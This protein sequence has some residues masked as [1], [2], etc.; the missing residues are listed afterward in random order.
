MDNVDV[1]MSDD[2]LDAFIP[3]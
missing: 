1:T 3:C 2:S